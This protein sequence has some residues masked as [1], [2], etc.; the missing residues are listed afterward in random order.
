M[1]VHVKLFA[2]LG[3]FAPHGISAKPFPLEVEPGSTLQD[4]VG[5]LKIP[6]EEVKIC[7]VNGRIMELSYCFQEGDE[8]GIFPPIGGG[9]M[10]FIQVD[11]WLYGDLAR[12]G[13]EGKG[14]GFAN[15]LVKL[16]AGAV[17]QD[18][19]DA[20]Q[21]NTKERGITFI[22]GNLAA[23][24]GLQPDLQHELQDNDRVAFFHLRAMWPF[25]YRHGAAMVKEMKEAMLEGKDQGLHHSYEEE[26]GQGE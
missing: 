22:N 21:M 17:M 1:L 13:G 26:K 2:T 14:T 3:M 6:D 18:L 5:R 16:P 12:F 19:L 15:L 25:Q 23:M 10:E 20:L 9:T 4:L 11:T 24:P 8:V 7:F